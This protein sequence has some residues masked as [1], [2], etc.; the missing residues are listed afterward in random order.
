MPRSAVK[1][2]REMSS[3]TPPTP[4][5]NPVAPVVIALFFVIIGVEA[6][7][8]LG[9]QGFVGGPNAV[10]WRVAAIQNYGFSAVIFD[11][12]WTN[13]RWPAEHLIRFVTYPFV[14]GSFI[15][16]FFAGGMLLALGKFVGDV[17]SQL[18]TL[19]VFV[20]SC[21]I[22][23]LA[24]GAL[25]DDQIPLFG[26]FPGVY[27]MI[28]AFTYLLWLRLGA[29]GAQQSRAFVLI[30]ALMAI[31]LV[32]GLLFGGSNVWVADLAGFAAGFGLSF[33]LSP[34]GWAK[35]RHK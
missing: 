2:S 6:A 16:A 8:T 19:A 9:A 26:A 10:G 18:A 33:F 32:F 28:G 22:G 15:H 24:Y 3:P 1:E 13:G 31:Q 12:M 25:L 35:L 5:V 14:H 21:A 23:A 30:G 11:W 4:A 7:F 27:G 29:E 34:G 20:G 17:F